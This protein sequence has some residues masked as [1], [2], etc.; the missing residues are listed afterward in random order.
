MAPTYSF[1]E[2]PKCTTRGGQ[3][4]QVQTEYQIG[5]KLSVLIS[6]C[7]IICFVVLVPNC[8]GAKFSIL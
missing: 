1:Q 8:P 7:Q 5:A 3:A 2:T 6:W 4:V